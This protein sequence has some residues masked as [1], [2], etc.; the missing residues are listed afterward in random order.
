MKKFSTV[1]TACIRLFCMGLFYLL[2]T[3]VAFSAGDPAAEYQRANAL[4]Q[5]QQYQEAAQIYEQ[6]LSQ[7]YVSPE[8]YYNLA[9]CYYKMNNVAK[10]VL[11][12]ERALKLKPDDEDISFNLK[13]AQLKVVDKIETVPEIFYRRWM[14]SI[15]GAFTTDGW[16]KLTIG[17]IWLIFLFAAVYIISSRT[18]LRRI[19]FVLAAFFL[20]V[21][22]GLWMITQQSYADRVSQKRAIVV[23][24][25]A[26]VKSSPGDTNTDLFLLHEGT[27]VDILDEFENWIKIRI[28]NGSVGWLKSPDIEEI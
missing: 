12:Y 6:L 9:N 27:K 10:T 20:L 23:S 14:K 16:T 7:E 4:Y 8:V 28:A 15:A 13:V 21:S 24:V 26:Y 18:S 11:N 3:S 1:I 17:S 2:F 25:S 19:G 22:I 5:K